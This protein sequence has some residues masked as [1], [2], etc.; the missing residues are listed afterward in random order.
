M[1]MMIKNGVNYSGGGGGNIELDTTLSVEGKAADAKAAG[2]AINALYNEETDYIAVKYDGNI[3]DVLYVGAQW[4]GHIYK[5]GDIY[6]D[7]TGGYVVYSG[8]G[9]I[10]NNGSVLSI[11]HKNSDTNQ[12]TSFLGSVKKIDLSK[13]TTLEVTFSVDATKG[14][15]N[16]FQFGISETKGGSFIAVKSY[17][18]GSACINQTVSI[19]ISNIVEGYFQ[20]YSTAG[21]YATTASFSKIL[22]K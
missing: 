12:A 4:D 19:D 2:D 14:S 5:T 18:Y 10:T 1:G 11:S 8:L 21:G 6:T 22:L 20:I 9:T 7:I 13:Y 17:P 15:Y 16:S 3:I